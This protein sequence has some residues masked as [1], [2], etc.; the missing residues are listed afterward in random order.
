M[1][2]LVIDEGD[3]RSGSGSAELADLEERVETLERDV[4][5]LKERVGANEED[6]KNIPELIKIE[7][8][9]ANSRTARLESE[10]A[11]LHRKVDAMPKVIAELVTEM[12][13]DHGRKS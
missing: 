8:R 7:F 3:F 2:V 1:F 13:A 6:M 4:S 10:V 5:A 12:L 11:E 9:L